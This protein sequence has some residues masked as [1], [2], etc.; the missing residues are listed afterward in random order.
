MNWQYFTNKVNNERNKINFLEDSFCRYLDRNI[1]LRVISFM[2][3]KFQSKFE[4]PSINLGDAR[5][6]FIFEFQERLPPLLKFA[7]KMFADDWLAINGNKK[8]CVRA[9]ALYLHRAYK[10]KRKLR[11]GSPFEPLWFFEFSRLD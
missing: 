2:P 11:P 6:D 8:F 9:M 3:R 5:N 1:R 4:H 7:W 10:P